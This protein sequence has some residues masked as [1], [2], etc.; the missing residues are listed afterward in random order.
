[1]RSLLKRSKIHGKTLPMDSKITM[2]DPYLHQI[3]DAYNLDLVRLYSEA[4]EYSRYLTLLH[5]AREIYEKDLPGSV[6]E[7]GV[8]KGLFAQ[9]INRFFPD[10]TLHLYDTFCGIPKEE[11]NF[12]T[13][14]NY[15][16]GKYCCDLFAYDGG[17]D[18]V[19]E[20]MSYPDKCVIHEGRVP[21]T[22][23]MTSD[24]MFCFVSIDCDVY[25]PT[26]KSLHYF[27]P[28]L[29]EDGYIF[30]HDYN[31]GT[32]D[33]YGIKRAVEDFQIATDTKL[34][35]V[36]ISDFSGTVVIVK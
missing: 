24:E 28:R 2:E 6:A 9:Y 30:I 29:V 19:M 16:N 1:M 21:Y 22:F 13:H 10:R 34:K 15:L 14:N 32:G 23:D 20:K 11:I 27:Y 18:V 25:L 4:I 26:L 36:P 33:F 8:Y 31:H 5:C 7:V 12:D 35:Y 17:I 3:E